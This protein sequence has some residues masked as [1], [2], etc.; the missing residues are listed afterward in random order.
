MLAITAIIRTKKGE[1][2]V[3]R[4]ALFEVARNI[5]ANEQEAVGYHISQDTSDPCVFTTYER[6]VDQAAKDRH[7]NSQTVARFFELAK[8]I[9]DG[10]VT[11]VIGTEI[12]AKPP[13]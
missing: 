13:D 6:Y 1:E 2:T 4:N 10:A 11:L 7:N 12:S 5:A 9:L 8:P 3:M